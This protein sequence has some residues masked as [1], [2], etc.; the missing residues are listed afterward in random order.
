[1]LTAGP[2]EATPILREKVAKLGTGAD[3]YQQIAPG[4]SKRGRVAERDN[5]LATCEQRRKAPETGR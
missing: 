1:M 3:A 4:Y 5:V 2:F